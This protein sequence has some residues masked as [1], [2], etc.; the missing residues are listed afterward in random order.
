MAS[1]KK[2]AMASPGRL[3]LAVTKPSSLR[4]RDVAAPGS[5]ISHGLPTRDT[6]RFLVRLPVVMSIVG[7]GSL[8]TTNSP[9]VSHP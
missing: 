1:E 9:I 3:V 4:L 5:S 8:S 2:L 7:G 6:R